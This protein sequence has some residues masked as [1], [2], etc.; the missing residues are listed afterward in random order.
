[1]L[2]PQAVSISFTFIGRYAKRFVKE[3]RKLLSY[4]EAPAQHQL[5]CYLLNFFPSISFKVFKPII[6]ILVV[7]LRASIVVVFPGI[8]TIFCTQNDI[9]IFRQKDRG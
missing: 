1:M 7:V 8:L 3:K 5:G 2:F 9:A 4:H 6:M